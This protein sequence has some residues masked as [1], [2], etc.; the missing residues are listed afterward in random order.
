MEHAKIEKFIWDILSNFQ[1]MWKQGKLRTFLRSRNGNAFSEKTYDWNSFVLTGFAGDKVSK[2]TKPKETTGT[3]DI[4]DCLPIQPF[5][6]VS[7]QGEGQACPKLDA[8]NIK[9]CS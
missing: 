3:S 9:E 8:Y 6:Q 2:E 1:T 4:K 5:W 7:T